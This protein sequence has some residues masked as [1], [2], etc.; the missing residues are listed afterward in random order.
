M[1]ESGLLRRAYENVH[2]GPVAGG[3]NVL[4]D[5]RPLRS[6]VGTILLAPGRAL[7]EA[8]AEEWRAQP[9]RLDISR[10]PLTRILGTALD[11]IPPSRAGV[12]AELAAYAETELVCHRAAHPP[13]LA[14]RQAEFWQP[15]LDWFARDLDAPLAVTTGVRAVPQPPA[16]LAAIRR[17]LAGLDHF[18]M[19]GLSIAVGA[20]GS[21]VVG[22]ALAAGRLDPAQA[23]ETAELDASFQ[24]ERWGEDQETSQRR[25]RLRADLELADRWLRLLGA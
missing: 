7:A 1:T 3:Y 20:A 22:M 25:A 10:A 11:R 19:A 4:L 6:P 18:R 12:E 24:I 21:L 16:S 15:L 14:R 2:V 23:F 13:E 8:V 9:A 5:A 17:A